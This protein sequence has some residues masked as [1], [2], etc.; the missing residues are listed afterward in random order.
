M[1]RKEKYVCMYVTENVQV[2]VCILRKTTCTTV[3]VLR[4]F[5]SIVDFDL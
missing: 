5:R 4:V 3:C 1:C 2:S